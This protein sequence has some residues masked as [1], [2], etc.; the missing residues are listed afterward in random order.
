MENR[1]KKGSTSPKQTFDPTRVFEKY[2]LH[3]LYWNSLRPDT[4]N[5]FKYKDQDTPEILTILKS[6]VQY[7]YQRR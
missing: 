1:P 4:I 2:L 3:S 6:T 7:L 5:G